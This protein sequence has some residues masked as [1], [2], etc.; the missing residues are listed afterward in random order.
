MNVKRLVF[1]SILAFGSLFGGEVADPEEEEM[2]FFEEE[3]DYD[4]IEG[5]FD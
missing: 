2:V 4:E 1:C 5:E 3:S